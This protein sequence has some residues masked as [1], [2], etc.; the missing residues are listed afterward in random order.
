MDTTRRDVLTGAAGLAA[1]TV[2]AL[3][4]PA[5]ATTS[6]D[7]LRR[8]VAEICNSPDGGPAIEAMQNPRP[9]ARARWQGG[10]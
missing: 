9:S 8:L 1:G 2:L 7:E 5:A 3:P 6:C 10:H 4:A